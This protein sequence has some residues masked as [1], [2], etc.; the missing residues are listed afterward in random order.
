MSS[1]YKE[2]IMPKIRYEK[3]GNIGLVQINRPEALNALNSEIVNDLGKIVDIIEAESDIRSVVFYGK[4]NFAAGADIKA[5]VDCNMK[6]AQAFSFST[7][8]NRIEKIKWPTIAAIEGYALGGGL[9]LA[10]ACDIRFADAK[11]KMGFPEINLGIMPGAGGTIRT[12]KLI[13][14]AAAK[15]MIFLGDTIDATK[16][17]QLGLINRISNGT[18][19]KD[20]LIFAEKLSE[21]APIALCTAKTAI[22]EGLMEPDIYKGIDQE[23]KK[24]SSLFETEDQKEGMRAFIEK[25]SPIYKGK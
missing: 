8:F 2:E 16:A 22:V 17:L 24:W 12:P 18:V 21:K 19:L 10:I 6:E 9:E 7:V 3:H 14:A 5:M 11:S 20:A 15:E 23:A 25:R 1:I 13:G 4:D